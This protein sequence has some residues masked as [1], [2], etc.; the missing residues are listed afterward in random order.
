MHRCPHN[1]SNSVFFY[2]Q[3]L[4]NQADP[5][6]A[7]LDA[8]MINNATS[9]VEDKVRRIIE[10]SVCR[11]FLS[12]VYFHTIY[13]LRMAFDY[14]CCIFYSTFVR[15]ELSHEII[16]VF[17]TPLCACICLCFIYN[18]QQVEKGD[19]IFEIRNLIGDF[20]ISG[21]RCDCIYS[22][23]SHVTCDC[24]NRTSLGGNLIS[25]E[26]VVQPKLVLMNICECVC[27]WCNA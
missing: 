25:I 19:L 14:Y 22:I 2:T 12:I 27:L 23:S 9:F 18:L 24:V 8:T 10:I 13:T 1:Q 21:H 17:V 3:K 4:K 26:S 16:A 15:T 5:H 6:S 11:V 7:K 20:A